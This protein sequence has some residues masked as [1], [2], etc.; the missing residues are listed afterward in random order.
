MTYARLILL[1]VTLAALHPRAASAS[2]CST[3]AETADILLKKLKWLA[4]TTDPANV[5]AR[6]VQSLPNIAATQVTLV[7]DT[8]ICRSALNAYNG[9]LLP[10]SRTSTSVVVVRF[11]STRFVV[12]DELRTAGEWLYTV[13]FNA[14]FTQ[15]YSRSRI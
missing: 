12:I 4:E 8:T 3:N 5:T 14:A 10:D 11:G 6:Q 1:A 9:A 7:A 13:V 2:P 15:V